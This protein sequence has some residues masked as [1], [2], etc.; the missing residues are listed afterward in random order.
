[1]LKKSYMH[2]N[3]LL[4]YNTAQFSLINYKSIRCTA[5]Y[6]YNKWTKTKP[7]RLF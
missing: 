4:I 7:M 1:M 2:T 5:I 3:T 6:R